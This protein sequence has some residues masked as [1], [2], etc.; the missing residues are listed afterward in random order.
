MRPASQG[1]FDGLC[2]IYAIINSMDGL[3]LKR[4]RSRFHKELFVSLTN[5]L[6]TNRLR[7]AMDRGLTGDDLSSAARRAFR[8][9]RET[10]GL[11]VRRPFARRSFVCIHEYA[12]AICTLP[13]GEQTVAIIN[14]SAPHYRHWTVACRVLGPWLLVRDSWNLDRLDLR[15]FNVDRGRY[16][17][18]TKDTLLLQWRSDRMEGRGTTP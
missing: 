15:R 8:T 16:N 13:E 1:A 5:A 6:P 12:A 4:P 2:G 10:D 18:R 3:G 7:A 14:V 17:I 11:E 9:L